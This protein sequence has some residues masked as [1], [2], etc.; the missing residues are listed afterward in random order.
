MSHYFTTENG[1]VNSFRT[2]FDDL[3]TDTIHY[4]N[5]A[6][7]TGDLVRYHGTYPIDPELS[8][9]PLD[10]F[11]ARSVYHYDRE[12]AGI[13][14]TMYRIT[15]RAHTDALIRAMQRGNQEVESG[16]HLSDEAASALGEIVDAIKGMVLMIDQIAAGSE[17]QSAQHADGDVSG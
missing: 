8:F 14:A 1:I 17:Q 6:N 16:L 13:D 3:W 5:Y 11:R 15:D 10:G 12:T 9:G 4:T 2:K 7:I